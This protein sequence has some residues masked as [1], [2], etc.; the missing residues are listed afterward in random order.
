[1]MLYNKWRDFVIW[2]THPERVSTADE[3]L[4]TSCIRANADEHPADSAAQLVTQTTIV[5]KDDDF[6]QMAVGEY[7]DVT[8]WTRDKVWCVRR[9]HGMEK[10]MYLPRHPPCE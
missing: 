9:A 3:R 2:P 6:E 5:D 1:M 7:G 4:D 8:I 10:L